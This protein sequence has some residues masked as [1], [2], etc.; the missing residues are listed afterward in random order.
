MWSSGKAALELEFWKDERTV[1]KE[2]QKHYL[3]EKR[4]V[5]FS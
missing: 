1:E 2:K 5:Q 3:E 4:L